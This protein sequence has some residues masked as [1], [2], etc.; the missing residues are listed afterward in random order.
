MSIAKKGDPK[1]AGEH[2]PK[3]RVNGTK[4]NQFARYQVSDVMEKVPSLA[5]CGAHL[6]EAVRVMWTETGQAAVVQEVPGMWRD[7]P[8][9]E[10]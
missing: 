4:C 10:G 9:A 3:K 6:G 2:C 5:V 8:N 1:F 7:K